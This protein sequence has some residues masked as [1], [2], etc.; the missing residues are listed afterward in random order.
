MLWE[1]VFYL[2]N[3]FK[4]TFYIGFTSLHYNFG[5]ELSSISFHWCRC[6]FAKRQSEDRVYFPNKLW[7]HFHRT[8]RFKLPKILSY[9]QII[10]FIFTV[11]E[12]RIRLFGHVRRNRNFFRGFRAIN[13]LAYYSKSDFFLSLSI[14]SKRCMKWERFLCFKQA[15][16]KFQFRVGIF[17]LHHNFGGEFSR[18]NLYWCR[19]KYAKERVS[20]RV[21]FP[22]RAHIHWER[23][24]RFKLPK[25]LSFFRLLSI[26]FEIKEERLGFYGQTIWN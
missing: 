5:R 3:F 22:N 20:G 9:C 18:I 8:H 19:C 15:I 6:K 7:L 10:Q 25:W 11:Q 4:F 1:R 21:Y 17:L 16:F 26:Y 2:R 12:D 14:L 24:Y 23:S 13:S